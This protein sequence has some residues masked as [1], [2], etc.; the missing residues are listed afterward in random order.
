MKKVLRSDLY[1]DLTLLS[2]RIEAGGIRKTSSI[3]SLIISLAWPAVVTFIYYYS[4]TESSKFNAEY[5]KG[6]L[7]FV[8]QDPCLITAIT[9]SALIMLIFSYAME[10]TIFTYNSLGER[11]RRESLIVKT[12]KRKVI[13][14]FLLSVAANVIYGCYSSMAELYFFYLTPIIILLSSSFVLVYSYYS[15]FKSGLMPGVVRLSCRA[16]YLS[17]HIADS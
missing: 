15:I 4:L 2:H 17:K 13:I 14:S 11:L 5:F 8:I 3:I 16:L 10:K 6:G 7:F 1:F 12:V 9:S